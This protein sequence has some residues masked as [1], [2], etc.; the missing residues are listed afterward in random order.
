[1]ANGINFKIMPST[2]GKYIWRNWIPTNITISINCQTSNFMKK[3]SMK[4]QKS[5][6]NMENKYKTTISIIY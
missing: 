3:K 1:M 6:L 4:A 5:C 2:Y